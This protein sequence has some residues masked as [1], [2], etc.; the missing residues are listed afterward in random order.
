MSLIL[1]MVDVNAQQMPEPILRK[2]SMTSQSSF[3]EAY[4]KVRNECFGN[5]DPIMN[6][7]TIDII[8]MFETS[9]QDNKLYTV[10]AA[11]LNHQ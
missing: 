1:T 6:K 11:C 9:T 7:V 3:G 5:I 10:V 4:M 8:S 2:I